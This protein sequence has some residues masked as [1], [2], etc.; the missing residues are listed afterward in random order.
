MMFLDRFCKCFSTSTAGERGREGGREEEREGREGGR[1]RRE[2][3]REG[4]RGRQREPERARER[5]R[6]RE[7]EVCSHQTPPLGSVVPS[8]CSLSWFH[9]RH[10]LHWGSA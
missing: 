2:G 8:A 3:G 4:D 5:E 1:E 7:R 10:T 9:K 6:E